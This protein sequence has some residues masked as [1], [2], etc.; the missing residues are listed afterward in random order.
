VIRNRLK[1]YNQKTLPVLQ[2]YRDKGIYV[3]VDGT[4]RMAA[5]A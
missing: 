2:F 5:G 4:A 3:E 1:E